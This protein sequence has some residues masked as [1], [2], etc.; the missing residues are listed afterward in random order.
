MVKD[1]DFLFYAS[2]L[3]GFRG[4]AAKIAW[5]SAQ[6]HCQCSVSETRVDLPKVELLS[7]PE[8]HTNSDTA[9]LPLRG[10]GSEY[11][12]HIRTT[13]RKGNM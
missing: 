10:S 7:N 5:A 12:L 9:F 3:L 11:V 4:K 1:V 6:I 2:A 13:H 8:V